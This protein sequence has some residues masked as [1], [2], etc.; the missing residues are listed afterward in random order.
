MIDV[1]IVGAGPAGSNCAYNLARKG[2]YAT[3]FD[4]SH[5]REKPCGGMIG[6]ADKEAFSI[7]EEFPIEHS[8]IDLMRIISPSRKIWNIDMTKNKLLCFSRMRFDQYLLNEA[9]SEG[10]N[11]IEE[12]V[13]GLQ[14][15]GES[16]RVITQKG[17]YDVRTLVGA[18]GV[19]S[20]IRKSIVGSLDKRDMGAC[21]GYIFKGAEEKTVT[22]KFL[23]KIEGYI[24]VIPRGDNTSIGGGTTK[25]SSFRE[26]KDQVNLFTKT[27][28][29][30]LEKVSEW[31][32]L[33]PNVKNPRTLLLQVAGPNWV[34]IGDA[35]GHVSPIS[36]SG[37]VYALTDG[38]LAAEAIAEGHV[39]QV[40]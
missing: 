31:A 27:G 7:L 33:I 22:I 6:M 32:A 21:F 20:L 19:S 39:E 4:H 9:L 16:W 15:N 25:I 3:M 8:E 2:I 35:A 12:K 38:E 18:D 14:K 17:S 5:P 23:P 29:S 26:L 10:A 28:Y 36:G 1:A 13:I 11:L 30:R 40:Q 34:L 24:W 37:I